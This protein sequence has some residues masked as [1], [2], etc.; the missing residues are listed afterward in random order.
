GSRFCFV[1]RR[2]TL[3]FLS[4]QLYTAMITAVLIITIT[5]ARA[6]DKVSRV[7]NIINFFYIQDVPSYL[8][9]VTK[10]SSYIFVRE[11][12]M[13]IIGGIATVLCYLC[14]TIVTVIM[15]GQVLIEL[16]QGMH[17]ASTSTKRYQKRAVTSLIFQV[18]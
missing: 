8:K 15:I 16:K 14:L 5:S 17:H 2:R 18:K 7:F 12:S 10:K 1:G 6:L 3:L 9:W 4:L 13:F 11:S